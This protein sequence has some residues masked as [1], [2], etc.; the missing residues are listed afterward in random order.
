M[1]L[2]KAINALKRCKAEGPDEIPAEALKA[3][4]ETSASM[5]HHKVLSDWRDVIIV[6]IPKKGDRRE[7]KTYRGTLLLSTPGKVFNRILLERLQIAADERLRENQTA[8]R[9][10]RSY[11]DQIATLG[12]ITEESIEWNSPVYVSVINFEKAFDSVD[13]ETLWKLMAHY[14]IHKFISIIKS[15]YTKH[16]GCPS[17]SF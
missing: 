14:D 16:K 2:R 4:T 10:G 17:E 11:G 15:T 3:D 6:K 8:F 12:I 5:L 7:G 9:N 13:C 1:V